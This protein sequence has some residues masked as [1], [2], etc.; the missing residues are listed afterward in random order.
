MGAGHFSVALAGIA[1]VAIAAWLLKPAAES[2]PAATLPFELQV[3]LGIGHDRGVL[4]PAFDAHTTDRRL[5][6]IATGRQGTA[7]DVTY[8]GSLREDGSADALVKALNRIE[9]VQN[10]TLQR[11]TTDVSCYAYG[12]AYEKIGPV[13]V[14]S[15]G[16]E[17]TF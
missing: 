17:A 16:L 15:L 9:G 8:R 13:T 3:R 5:M 14:P 6:S 2:M 11:E 4:A 1:I 12:C 7:V 10:V